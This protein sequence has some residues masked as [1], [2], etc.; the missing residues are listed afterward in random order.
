MIKNITFRLTL[1]SFLFLFLASCSSL[2]KIEGVS[3]VTSLDGKMLFLRSFQAGEWV[4]LDSA[5]VVHG[6][7]SMKGEADTARMVT[8]YMDG[9]G[10]MP[11]VLENGVI[12]VSIS[13]TQLYAKGSPLNDALYN[14]IEK[15]NSI[16]IA[17]AELERKEARMVLDGAA[18][19]DIQ[20]QLEKEKDALVKEMDDCVKQF[21]VSNYNNVLGPGVFAMICNT[22]PY[23]VLTSRI[24]EIIKEAPASFKADPQVKEFLGKAR[25]NM[26][27]IEEHQ[28]LEE[29]VGM[30]TN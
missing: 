30:R 8:L 23:P 6:L 25:E 12:K 14:F 18:L 4:T 15:R 20:E 19:D 16:E 17:L 3:S 21:I 10:L 13:N 11:L 27:L 7:F 9:E 1:P 28:R 24:E 5:E 29:N 22:L 26:K 2:Y